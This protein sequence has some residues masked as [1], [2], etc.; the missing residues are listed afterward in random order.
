MGDI[1][2][3]REDAIVNAA[4]TDLILGGG[5]AGAIRIKGGPS[6]Q[7]ECDVYGP[8]VLGEAVLTGAG[9]LPAE[10]V[11]H[12][13]VMDLGGLP[14]MHSIRDATI[15]SLEIASEE[16][17][18]SISFPALGTGIGGFDMAQAAHIL[19][20]ATLDF[21]H[22]HIFPRWV[23]FVLFDELALEEFTGVWEELTLK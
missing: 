19:L 22:S 18:N 2:T 9:D 3:E 7:Q 15:S 4:N 13:A 12:A 23:R 20:T 17:F 8:V 10:Y 5:V 16:Q 11:I 14:T 6:I 21:L 1:T